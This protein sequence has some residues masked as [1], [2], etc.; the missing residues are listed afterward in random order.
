[1]DVSEIE[2]RVGDL[3]EQL[4]RAYDD[5]DR[6]RKE[7]GLSLEDVFVLPA[8][9][10]EMIE[11]SPE[12]RQ[13]ADEHARKLN[14]LPPDVKAAVARANEIGDVLLDAQTQLAFILLEPARAELQRM[15]GLYSVVTEIENPIEA[16][17]EWSIWRWKPSG[18]SAFASDSG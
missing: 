14:A 17:N 9:P 5:L 6:I 10:P 12:M 3:N 11:A 18:W 4:T 2:Q 13:L 15:R 7:H 1:M 8:I 16:Y